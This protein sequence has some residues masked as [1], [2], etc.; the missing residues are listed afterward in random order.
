[1]DQ[2]N[3]QYTTIKDP[4][5]DFIYT[6][7]K[8]FSSSANAYKPQPEEL[9]NK[10][11][12]KYNLP[13]EMF[14]LTAGCDEGIQMFLHEYGQKT[15]VFTPTYIVYKDAIEFGNA[16]NEIFSIKNNIF[17]INTAKI[18]NSTLIFL[19]NPNNPSGF[20]NKEKTLELIR[21][22][23]DCIVVVDEAYG[24]F[25]PELSVINEIKN[26]PNLAVLRSFSK[27]YGMAGNR[28]GYIIS[29]PSIISKVKNKTQWS[30]TSYLS[31]GAAC[32]ALDHEEYFEKMR[33]EIAEV[34]HDFCQFLLKKDYPFLPSRIN[35]VV[36]KFEN[37]KKGTDFFEYL[38]SSDIIT[39]HGNG[40][41]NIGLDESYVRIA[42]GNRQQMEVVKD[43][44]TKYKI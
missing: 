4:L 2:I 32:V 6:G 12:A 40:F 7:L 1:M 15:S 31:V 36:L 20:T 34:R 16:F 37:E 9:V 30:N 39:S 10:L 13:P 3:L 42:I 43:V 33:K 28:I 22:S 23:S 25:A 14:Y 11:A 35:A 26:Y 41:S 24:E 29:N 5:P 44:I 21:N 17:D 19:A 18:E 8:R 27:G 38:K